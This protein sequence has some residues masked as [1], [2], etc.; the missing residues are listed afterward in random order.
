MYHL[1]QFVAVGGLMSYGADYNDTFQQCVRLVDR[2]LAGTRPVDLPVEQARRFAFVINQ[3]TA[4][5]LGLTIAPAV[6]LRADA[7]VD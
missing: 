3:K 4:R 1:R 6:P 7:V 2:I 5:T